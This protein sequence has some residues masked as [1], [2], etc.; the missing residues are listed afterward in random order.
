M[1]CVHAPSLTRE[2]LFPV[3]ET[4]WT[5]YE[6]AGISPHRFCKESVAFALFTT[7]D[8]AIGD[9]A[10][11]CLGVHATESLGVRVATNFVKM[12]KRKQVARSKS[13]NLDLSIQILLA[14][15]HRMVFASFSRSSE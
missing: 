13:S 10:I 3:N 1:F 7:C 12:I 15:L 5:N 2:S 8:L 4:P 14:V 9:L 6:C 11:K